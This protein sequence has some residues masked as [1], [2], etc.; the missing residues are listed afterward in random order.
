MLQKSGAIITLF[1]AQNFG[2]F[3][4]GYA[5]QT[6]MERLGYSSKFIRYSGLDLAE[7]VHMVK[8]KNV[9]LALFR[10]RQF[11][12]Y[13][14][15]RKLLN[16]DSKIYDGESFD[17][18]IVGS[19]TLWD[20][21]NP[22]IRP[23]DYFLGKGINS[24]RIVAYAPSANGTSADEF[25]EVYPYENPF[26]TFT[27]I[28]VRDGNTRYLVNNFTEEP[29]VVLDPTLLLDAVDYP[30]EEPAVKDKYVMV[31]GYSFQEEERKA[32]LAEAKRRNAKTV[33]VGL[34]NSWCDCSVSATVPEFLGYLK[35][36]ECVFTST[37][38]GTI[39]S[40]IMQ[41]N[42][43]TYARKNYK[44][45]DLLSRLDLEA[46]NGSNDII[47]SNAILSAEMDYPAIHDRV[48]ALRDRSMDFLR[49]NL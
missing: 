48:K 9:K 12:K 36:A 30:L 44:V 22:T 10:L 31:Y 39:F 5:M 16:V 43:V 13:L 14:A 37:F 20:V 11:K 24:K 28:G 6:V 19:D 26:E 25:A 42:F 45:L 34:L 49:S 8:T 3:L 29:V 47:N 32:I 35:N 18:V 15:S 33:S 23:T 2:A 38:H 7:F 40:V 1:A 41:K 27:A 46:R 17:A 4:Q 21:Q